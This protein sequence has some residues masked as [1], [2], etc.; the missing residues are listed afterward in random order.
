V[1]V[2]FTDG[3]LDIDYQGRP[4]ELHWDDEPIPVHSEADQAPALDRARAVLCRPDGLIDTLRSP[5]RDVSK[6][7]AFIA[8]VAFGDQDFDLMR[9]MAL[10]TGRE[11]PCGKRPP[12]GAFLA[13]AD[14]PE[15][16]E[17]LREALLGKADAA[18]GAIRTC[19][20]PS[21]DCSQVGAVQAFDFPFR[22]QE[23]LT[24][25]NLLSVAGD[26]QVQ[27]ALIT[28]SGQEYPLKGSSAGRLDNGVVITIKQVVETVQQVSATLPGDRQDWAGQWR[29]RYR[30]SDP[31]VA[32][33]MKNRASIYVFGSLEAHLRPGPPLRKGRTGTLIVELVSAA[34]QPASQGAYGPGS[35]L[36]V[37]AGST[38]LATPPVSPDGSFQFS[39][40][41]PA[42]A[43]TA[44]LPITALLRPVVRLSENV[45][46][47]ELPTWEGQLGSVEVR[48]RPGYPL[49][50]PPGPLGT[51]RKA[52]SSRSTDVG[53]DAT[54]NEAGGCIS[55]IRLGF[56]ALPPGMAGEPA[57]RL[58]DG[59][60]TLSPGQPCP[61]SL[62]SGERRP[63]RL[64]LELSPEQ[65]RVKEGM[66]RGSLVVRSTSS[67]DPAQT[68]DFTYE[69]GTKVEPT[70]LRSENHALLWALLLLGLILP[71][72]LLYLY[73]Q[74][75]RLAFGSDRRC[76][77]RSTW[78]STVRQTKSCSVGRERRASS[79]NSS[80]RSR[81]SRRRNSKI[82]SAVPCRC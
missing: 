31:A 43:P 78:R 30:A 9:S 37:K 33:R 74:L 42:D 69:F 26:P 60:R 15:L 24:A 6:D 2:W 32:E 8:A 61:V 45:P 63:L 13:A 4:K 38:T 20:A 21:S 56:S 36:V 35:E 22:L 77:P 25:F 49:V 57:A 44:A 50:D 79:P 28:P 1:L 10:G 27:A 76:R 62:A 59:D 64:Q 71:V 75:G 53:L 12:S 23:G 72:S 46:P 66:I 16:V 58:S 11:G 41:I 54:G 5:S 65:L 14:V 81:T 73:N 29:I 48:P 40:D 80:S 18:N 39:L 19:F 17:R 55:L 7:G 82:A 3:Q 67:I 70:I 47:V 34:G 52:T 68:E 51:L